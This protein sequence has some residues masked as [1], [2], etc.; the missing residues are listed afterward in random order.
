V[1]PNDPN[2]AALGGNVSNVLNRIKPD[3]GLGL[4]LYSD[5]YF[6]GVSAQQLLPLKTTFADIDTVKTKGKLVPHI[7][8]TAGYRFFI[9]DDISILPSVMAKYVPN[10]PVSQFDVNVKAQYQDLLW[11]GASY[12]HQYGYAAMAGINVSNTFNVGYAYDYTTT[13]LN[14]FSNG[15][16]EIILGFLLGN[17]YGDWCPRNVW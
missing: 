14:T 17:K 4:W 12:R 6:A 10:T 13:R 2:D 15:T 3:I 11:V 8:A 5:R 9:N 16:H 7:F 1:L